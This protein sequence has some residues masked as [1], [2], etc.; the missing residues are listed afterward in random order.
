MSWFFH[1][2]LIRCVGNWVWLCASKSPVY[3]RLL[4][5]DPLPVLCLTLLVNYYF[6]FLNTDFVHVWVSPCCVRVCTHAIA[7]KQRS[8]DRVW[9]SVFSLQHVESPGLVTSPFT[10]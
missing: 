3:S 9:E 4:G 6:L 7:Y 2:W 1:G 10:H 5:F 8:D